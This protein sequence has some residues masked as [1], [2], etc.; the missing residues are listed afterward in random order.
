M[1][2]LRGGSLPHPLGDALLPSPPM[3]TQP[4]RTCF[5]YGHALHA[6]TCYAYLVGYPFMLLICFATPL[7][8]EVWVPGKE[9]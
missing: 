7:P 1:L 4:Y 3:L 8:N 6:T 5:P 9:A 2:P